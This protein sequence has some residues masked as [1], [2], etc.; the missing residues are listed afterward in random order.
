MIYE[1][2]ER[3]VT[4]AGQSWVAPNATVVGSVVLGDETSVWF[5]ATVRG[6]MDTIEIGPQSNVQDGAVLHTDP[7]LKLVLGQGVTVGHQA[8]LHGC[9]V[10]DNSLIGIGATVLNG[11]RIGKD[12]IIGAHAL[13]T[14]G[15]VIPDRSLVMGAPGKVVR[16]LDD[17]TVAKLRLSAAHYVANAKRFLAELKADAR[18]TC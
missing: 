14:E 1:L 7:G 3:R 11:A 8:M 6:D 15:K 2:G 9:T 10:G 17:A 5:N 12:C 18:F 13:I 4:A 16:E